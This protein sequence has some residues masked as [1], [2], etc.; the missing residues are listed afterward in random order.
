MKMALPGPKCFMPELLTPSLGQGFADLQQQK[1]E[2]HKSPKFTFFKR[3][4]RKQLEKSYA[5]RL[6]NKDLC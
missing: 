4:E 6:E 5:N 3:E 2:F 1:F